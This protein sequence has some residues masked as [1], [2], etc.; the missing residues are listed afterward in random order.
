MVQT[1]LEQDPF[2]GHVF[3]FR[4]RRGHLIKVLWGGS[5]DERMLACSIRRSDHPGRPEAS[6]CCLL[7]SLKTLLLPTKATLPYVDV[8]VPEPCKR[9]LLRKEL[10]LGFG[11]EDNA[12][13]SESPA[14][15]H[16]FAPRAVR[17][18]RYLSTM[19]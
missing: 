6:T 5:N 7:S 8:N 9:L 17:F 10:R 18:D 11:K 16:Q 15:T 4:G 19:L 3:V 12:I 1:K 13:S 2:S 14:I